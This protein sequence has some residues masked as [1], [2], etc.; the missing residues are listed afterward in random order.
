MTGVML[1]VARGL[2][3]VEDAV[4]VPVVGD[5]R[6]QAG[7]RPPPP[8]TT[9]A[10][11]AAPSSIEYSVCRWRWT[12]E[13]LMTPANPFLHSCGLGWA[14][15]TCC[16]TPGR[17]QPGEHDPLVDPS[18]ATWAP[19]RSCTSTHARSSALGLSKNASRTAAE[20]GS[21]PVSLEGFTEA[22]SPAS[23]RSIARFTAAPSSDAAAPS[24][25]S[26]STSSD[27][28]A[29]QGHDVTTAPLPASAPCP[30][31]RLTPPS[32]DARQPDPVRCRSTGRSP[33]ATP[34][35]CAGLIMRNDD[36]SWCGATPGPW[37]GWWDVPSRF[38][39]AEHPD[40]DRHQ[41]AG[42]YGFTVEVTSYLGSWLDRYRPTTR[43]R[44]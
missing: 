5:A 16:A 36:C 2:V 10:I 8:P 25:P 23:R 32:S 39:D 24:G 28:V 6:P 41:K 4:H 9:S 27:Q 11:R 44:S 3:E 37:L 40:R 43:S 21:S 18:S 34:R 30:F 26:C 13:R 17:D 19:R 42:E 33:G 35:P 12:N 20:T 22:W 1:G 15:P 7:R 31:W 38:C 14:T 29:G